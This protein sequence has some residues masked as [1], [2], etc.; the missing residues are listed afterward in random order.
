MRRFSHV[1]VPPVVLY[2]I[3]NVVDP[4]DR[5]DST[6]V[7]PQARLFVPA[8]RSALASLAATVFAPLTSTLV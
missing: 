3:L 1:P 5:P 2:F 8:H 4:V 7:M 6:T